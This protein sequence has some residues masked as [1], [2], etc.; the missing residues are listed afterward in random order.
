VFPLQG[1]CLSCVARAA[2]K[3]S[4]VF[5]YYQGMIFAQA[6]GFSKGCLEGKYLFIGFLAIDAQQPA[7]SAGSENL[8]FRNETSTN[9]LSS[10]FSGFWNMS[11]KSPAFANE[12]SPFIIIGI[13]AVESRQKARVPRYSG[14][15]YVYLR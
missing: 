1:Q 7:S 10:I 11:S 9:S 4:P 8:M 3:Q 12:N 6:Q 2:F 5:T 14:R 13:V 15:G